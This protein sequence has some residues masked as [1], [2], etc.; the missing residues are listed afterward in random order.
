MTN[1]I[2]RKTL[3]DEEILKEV[4]YIKS[5]GYDHI[6]LVTGEANRTVGVPYLKHAI[7]LI[8]EHFSNISIE[9][10]PLDQDEY[11]EL[12]T[13]GLYAVLVYQ[14]TYHKQNYKTFHPKGRKSILI[15]D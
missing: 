2:P 15:T 11:E 6:L 5:L 7:Q 8:R 1:V 14:E 3:S 4:A 10:Q 13:E 9:V 12:I